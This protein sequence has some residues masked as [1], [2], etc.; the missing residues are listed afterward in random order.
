MKFVNLFCLAIAATRATQDLED[1]YA[2]TSGMEEDVDQSYVPEE[3]R[4]YNYDEHR[5]LATLKA[6]AA[7]CTLSSECTN[8]CCKSV[9]ANSLYSYYGAS[10]QYYGYATS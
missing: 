2:Y 5:N 10:T 6:F 1:P 9:T 4:S 8:K 7:P 3:L